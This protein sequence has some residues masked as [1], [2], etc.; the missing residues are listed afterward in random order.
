M[1]TS[2]EELCASQKAILS[3]FPLQCPGVVGKDYVFIV[4][5]P[6]DK[7]HFRSL[8]LTIH[9]LANVLVKKIMISRGT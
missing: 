6:A 1:Q 5:K 9:T 8:L 4:G 7:N 2:C 3:L